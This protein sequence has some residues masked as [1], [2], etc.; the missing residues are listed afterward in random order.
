[1]TGQWK[2]LFLKYTPVINGFDF[3]RESNLVQWTKQEVHT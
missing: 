3:N 2:F 1:M